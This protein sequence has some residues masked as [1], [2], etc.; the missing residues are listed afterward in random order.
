VTW[1]RRRHRIISRVQGP[2]HYARAECSCGAQFKALDDRY[3]LG[4]FEFWK[5]DHHG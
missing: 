4:A 5:K 2:D 3:M 1:F